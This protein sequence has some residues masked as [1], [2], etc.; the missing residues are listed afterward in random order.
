MD[1]SH[2]I[3]PT[4]WTDE[5]F[6]PVLVQKVIQSAEPD[7]IWQNINIVSITLGEIRKLFF[8]FSAAPGITGRT[9]VSTEIYFSPA[10]I[11]V[12]NT[13]VEEN[14]QVLVLVDTTVDNSILSGEQYNLYCYVTLDDGEILNIIGQV[15]FNDSSLTLQPPTGTNFVIDVFSNDDSINVQ[16]H[17]GH[18]DVGIN[19]N[20][21]NHFNAPQSFVEA[22]TQILFASTSTILSGTVQLNLDT[23]GQNGYVATYVNGVVDWQPNAAGAVDSVTAANGS[24]VISPNVGAVLAAINE[25][26]A[27]TWLVNQIFSGSS[28]D[29]SL[30]V[31]STVNI[32]D[33]V[34]D[35]SRHAQVNARSGIRL[36]TNGVA[37]W[38]AGMLNAGN[39][40]GRGSDLTFVHNNAMPIAGD[41]DFIMF[42]SGDFKIVNGHLQMPTGA[43]DGYRLTA[44]GGN[45]TAI[46]AAGGE[47]DSVTAADNSLVITP[48]AGAVT[49]KINPNAS[50]TWSQIQHFANLTIGGG[51][52]NA[53]SPT[54]VWNGV[55]YTQA[56]L[57]ITGSGPGTVTAPI[58]LINVAQPLIGSVGVFTVNDAATFY[59]ASAP[60]PNPINPVAIVN[61][62]SI[63]I[64]SG[65]VR[66]DGGLRLTSGATT[67]Y[68]WHCDDSSGNGSWQPSGSGSVS[69]I[70]AG[71]GL[72]GGVITTTGTIA[73][74]TT[75][76]NSWTGLQTFGNHI[77]LGGATLNVSALT[78][79][80]VLQYNGSNW[81]NANVGT[82][83]SVATNSTLTGG[84]ITTTGTLGIDLTNPNSWTGL[85]TFGNHISIGGATLNV[86]SLASGN[87]LQYNGTNWVNANGNAGTVTSVVAGTGLSGGT[88]TSTGTV[89][90]DT[91]HVNGWTGQQYAAQQTI[92]DS[93]TIS[94]NAN[95]QQAAIL[96]ITGNHTLALP[97]N[98]QAGATYTL[99]VKQDAT[100]SRTLAY[101]SGYKWSNGTTPVLSTA[102]NAVDI[103]TFLSDGTSM[104]G[105]FAPNFS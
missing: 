14:F 100:G 38:F 54:M 84:P 28:S 95:T 58:R 48:N 66:F 89:S 65:L 104:Y 88:I 26:F 17:T 37:D 73:L 8:D 83:T 101:A 59:I 93:S 71:S 43:V 61:A 45:G 47:V 32:K 97:S 60:I 35:I 56:Q 19:I 77:S 82:V 51:L 72:S 3:F 2:T 6:L 62:Y 52:V 102:A 21:S 81:I 53:F 13:V 22:L 27:N 16:P 23:P 63:W 86:S 15:L 46:W 55:D 91:S 75:A 4:F 94:W 44:S 105:A 9:I 85:Q 78:T 18:V 103:I 11:P 50:L 34:V 69:S 39:A 90:L 33:A 96:T 76:I 12:G 7:F 92:T 1:M 74:D 31:Q 42:K 20:H 57:T 36:K 98:I 70:T 68:F 80:N 41:G 5:F 25:S 67:G 30:L 49:A 99:I 79:N 24:L 64:A 87:F 29:T 40:D 10:D